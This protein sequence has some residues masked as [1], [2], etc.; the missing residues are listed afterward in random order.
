MFSSRIIK[1]DLNPV[2]EETA[3]LLVNLD[4]VKLKEQL[5]IQLWDSDRMSA[6]SLRAIRNPHSNSE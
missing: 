4:N 2:F 6:V 1:D 3:I 5:S